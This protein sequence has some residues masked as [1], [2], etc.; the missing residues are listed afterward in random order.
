ML[1]AIA[2]EVFP[3]TLIRLN[4]KNILQIL[5]FCLKKL[6]LGHQLYQI[7]TLG[8]RKVTVTESKSLLI[9]N[10]TINEFEQR[11][12]PDVNVGDYCPTTM[13]LYVPDSL[14]IDKLEVNKYLSTSTSIATFHLNRKNGFFIGI[15]LGK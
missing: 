13:N 5:I 9:W 7:E 1:K 10:H 15:F 3:T 11:L 14:I 6:C 4:T 12:T 2:Q 8:G